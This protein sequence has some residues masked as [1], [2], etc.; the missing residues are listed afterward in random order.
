MA[1]PWWTFEQALND[2]LRELEDGERSER[3]I[4]GYNW[5]LRNMF[6]ALWDAHMSINPRR[7]GRKEIDYLRNEYYVGCSSRYKAY[8]IGLLL[9]F[10]RWAGNTEIAKIKLGWGNLEPTK[11]RWLTDEQARAVRAEVEGIEKMLVH[12]ELD[13]GM[14]RIEVLRLKVGSFLTGHV[15]T[16]QIHGKGR[17]G[18]KH[19]TIYWHPDTGQILEEYLETVR[20]ETI[21]RAREVDPKAK[22]PDEL[23]IYEHKGNL[24]PYKKTAIDRFLRRLGERIGMKLSNHDL[25]R[26]CGRMMYRS[27]VQIEIIARIFGHTDTRTTARYLGLD[28]ED[29]N[30]A[31]HK[32]AQYQKSQVV[33]KTVQIEAEPERSGGP[34]EI[35]TPDLPVISRALQPG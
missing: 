34:K 4:K 22:V 7:I 15:N 32:Y 2:Y 6:Q 23:F 19:R 17:Y 13:L 20:K 28:L 30:S 11:A 24:Y 5:A 3:T 26:T 16:V 27:G 35:W 14:R 12:C 33:P 25:R 9:L 10:L 1:R 29:M 31:M 21:R 8:Q 18:G